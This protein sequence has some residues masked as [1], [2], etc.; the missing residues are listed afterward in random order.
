M[1]SVN[2]RKMKVC[3]T[4]VARP[5]RAR[6]ERAKKRWETAGS[7]RGKQF[8]PVRGQGSKRVKCRPP[9]ASMDFQDRVL[10]TRLC[11]ETQGGSYA[12]TNLV[13]CFHKGP[14]ISLEFT[15]FQSPSWFPFLLF[16]PNPFFLLLWCPSRS[17][18]DLLFFFFLSLCMPT[19]AARSRHL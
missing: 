12:N 4:W 2:L 16:I 18:Q 10:R 3:S 15:H 17:V 13:A 6:W 7:G 19:Q 11:Q 1:H 5:W 14:Y 8:T 9:G